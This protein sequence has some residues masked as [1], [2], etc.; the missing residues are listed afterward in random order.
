MYSE[1]WA[2]K[3]SIGDIV[4][5]IGNNVCVIHNIV[6]CSDGVYVMYKV[7]REVTILQ[8]G[9]QEAKVSIFL[10]MFF[11]LD[12]FTLKSP[13]PTDSFVLFGDL[14]SL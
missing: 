11:S 5:I 13:S 4:F 2:I 3:V 14:L 9:K 10:Q 7:L 6:K 8:G 1:Q 12:M